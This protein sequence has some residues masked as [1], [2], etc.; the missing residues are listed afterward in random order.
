[1]LFRSYEVTVRE[2]K[3]AKVVSTAM[4]TEEG[5]KACPGMYPAIK[6]TVHHVDDVPLGGPATLA[7]VKPFIAP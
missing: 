3:T 6:N 5:D 7:F 1:M 2:A 4:V